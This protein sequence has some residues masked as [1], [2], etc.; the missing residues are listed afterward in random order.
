[1]TRLVLHLLFICA[2]PVALEAQ[3]FMPAKIIYLSGETATGSI[4]AKNWKLTPQTLRFKTGYDNRETALDVSKLAAFSISRSDGHTEYY[5]RRVVWIDKSTIPDTTHLARLRRDTL[6]LQ[7]LVEGN[8]SLYAVEVTEGARHFFAGTKDSLAELIYK[9]YIKQKTP[10]TSVIFP[11]GS[12]FGSG[13]LRPQNSDIVRVSYQY[14]QQLSEFAAGKMPLVTFTELPWGQQY[15]VK[16]IQN[17]NEA[18]EM[19]ITYVYKDE[20]N[21]ARWSVAVGGVLSNFGTLE[22]GPDGILNASDNTKLPFN[23][24]FVPTAAVGYEY[25]FR[26]RKSRL[27]LLNELALTAFKNGS[28]TQAFTLR[29]FEGKMNALYADLNT[30]LRI[31]FP[32]PKPRAA[33]VA[34]GLANGL[35]LSDNNKIIEREFGSPVV[36]TE[37]PLFARSQSFKSGI[38]LGIGGRIGAFGLEARYGSLMTLGQKT[39]STRFFFLWGSYRF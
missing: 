34:L 39:L 10:E 7:T 32:V 4:W 2:I 28:E 11:N 30:M 12:G 6:I 36:T 9:K 1:M 35:A 25:Y 31:Y 17:I 8:I 37:K 18:L 19:P 23:P 38:L 15:L 27:S 26:S 29:E 3:D 21:A 20:K 13:T 33:F 16:T 14:R 5:I 22:G 24:L